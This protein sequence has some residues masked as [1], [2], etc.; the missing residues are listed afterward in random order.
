MAKSLYLSSIVPNTGKS[1]LSLGIIDTLLTKTNSVGYFK[2]II[3]LPNGSKEGTIQ[4]MLEFFHLKQTYEESYSYTADEVDELF[5]KGEREQVL[6]KIIKDYK[7]L[8]E[9]FDVV[10]VDG[11]D[12]L[13]DN[14]SYEFAFN[15]E[16]AHN[17]G[18]PVVL[19]GR[20][21]NKDTEAA[22]RQ[23][24]LAFNAFEEHDV[25]VISVIINRVLPDE[26]DHFWE[27]LKNKMGSTGKDRLFCSIP[28]IPL[29]GAPSIEEIAKTLDAEILFGEELL[30]TKLMYRILVTGMQMPHFLE[31]LTE[32]C[33]VVTAS[34][35]G[36]IIVGTLMANESENYPEVSGL[37][38]TGAIDIDDSIKRL[39]KGL[40]KPIPII[41]V[42]TNTFETA[43][44]LNAIKSKLSVDYPIKITGSIKAFNDFVDKEHLVKS[45]TSFTSSS[46]TPK[47]FK[48][49]LMQ[50]AK[51][52][53]K[54][55]V[56]PEG[57]DERILRGAEYLIKED[58]VD[59]TL[60]GDEKQI[61]DKIK[62]LGLKIPLDKIQLIDP[63]KHPNF[64]K[65]VETLYKLRKHKKMTMGIAEDLMADPSYYGTMMVHLGDADGMVSGAMNTTQHTIKPALQFI[66]TKPGVNVVSSIFFMCMEDRVLVYGDCAV[67]PNPNAE[68]LAEIAMSSSQTAVNFGIDPKV[69]MLSYSSGESGK[70]EEVDK[71]RK[72][73]TI[74]KQMRPDIAVEGPIQYDAAVHEST[75][76]KKLPNSP[77]AGKANVLIFP[78]LNTGNNTYKA[79]ERETGALAI[80]PVLQGLNKPVNDLSRGCSVE[81]VINTVIITSIQAQAKM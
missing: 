42:P 22:T 38:L 23:A 9:R 35:R 60:I 45:I 56:L 67:N 48:Y 75:G 52:A 16:I 33:V 18:A 34:D 74:V 61:T 31:H 44:N 58:I 12:F 50:K 30:K 3:H 39:I 4:I 40:R 26:V 28:E 43:V 80:G 2:P 78:D 73:T 46:M 8:E 62:R 70:G 72:A 25:E 15:A 19:V 37:V 69:A 81:D 24:K 57:N 68:Q 27:T 79:V 66:K 49:Q 65:Y 7:V 71:V 5:E 76:M 1:V 20:G 13:G 36:D 10:L 51:N 6:E 41:K 63:V 77:I 64:Q 47:M 17:I 53:K 29:L 14:N 11:T 21:T 59:L 55:I 54:H 32:N